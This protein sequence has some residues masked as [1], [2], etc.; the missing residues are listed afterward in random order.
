MRVSIKLESQ[1]AS[2]LHGNAATTSRTR[3]V[4][5]T[6][7]RHG[8]ALRPMHPGTDDPELRSYFFA[9]VDEEARAEELAKSLREHE[10]VEGAYIKPPDALP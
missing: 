6:A 5:E 1:A 3:A 9:D 2:E 10:A 7:R 4:V 8:A